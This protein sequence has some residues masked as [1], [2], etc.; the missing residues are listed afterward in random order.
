[1]TSSPF[2]YSPTLTLPTEIVVEIFLHFLPA[3]PLCPPLGGL[4][5]PTLLAQICRD[6]REI[7][8]ATPRLW[9]TISVDSNWIIFP[10]EVARAHIWLQRS[11]PLP[12]SLRFGPP[13]AFPS[14][15]FAAIT[16]YRQRWAYLDLHLV[17]RTQ[18][19]A[20]RDGPTPLL[21]C[22]DLYFHTRTTAGDPMVLLNDAP[23]LHTVLL[24]FNAAMLVLPWAQ[25]TSLTL[26]RVDAP[27]RLSILQS[28]SNLQRLELFLQLEQGTFPNAQGQ[29]ILIP[30]L[31]SLK[32]HVRTLHLPLEPTFILPALRHLAIVES[33]TNFERIPA[34]AT[35]I[36]TAGCTQL[37]ELSITVNKFQ[38]PLISEDAYRKAF[39]GVRVSFAKREL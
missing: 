7:A 39:P 11:H 28:A 35:F 15:F 14:P 9:R 31:E 34:L 27:G 17:D 12:L 1:M 21:R 24:N 13:T 36:A 4:G 29:D 30:R 25:L 32:L 5:S 10:R 16:P 33:R 26:K 6:W 38:F 8:L 20:L 18:L 19:A 23:L 22:I 37:D 3:Y 2:S